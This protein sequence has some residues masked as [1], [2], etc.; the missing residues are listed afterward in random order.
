[1]PKLNPEPVRDPQA[2]RL[3]TPE[4]CLA[5]FIDY[6]PS[7]FS[8][9]TSAPTEEILLN[10]EAV[11]RLA[12]LY[13]IPTVVTTVAVDMGVNEP[14]VPALMT[15]LGHVP[16]IDRTGVNA[17]E[18]PDV[19]TAIQA[20]GRRKIVI[21]GLWTEVCLAFPTIDL[22]AEGYDVFPVADA[23]GGISPAAHN[24]AFE[25]MV[26]AGAQPI[27]AISFG[28]EL[29]RNWARDDS[30]NLRQVMRWYF[31]LKQQLDARTVR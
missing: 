11:A 12:R 21:C 31:P 19:R 22:L 9:V 20:T 7:Q 23:V 16:E 29:M 2:D 17:W 14:T 6:Q 28:C 8:T 27:T 1:M 4:N 24:R 15:A 18:D 3:L 13:D 5:V 30:D 26:T 10:A 25:R